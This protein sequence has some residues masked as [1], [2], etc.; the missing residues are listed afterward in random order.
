MMYFTVSVRLRAFTVSVSIVALLITCDSLCDWGPTHI[1][2]D[3]TGMP[4][5]KNRTKKSFSGE[6]AAPS[7]TRPA[8]RATTTAGAGAHLSSPET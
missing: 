5:R 1:A 8:P 3:F 7:A 6:I 2:V 4:T